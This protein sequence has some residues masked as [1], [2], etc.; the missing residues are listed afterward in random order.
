T[1]RA[2]LLRYEEGYKNGLFSLTDIETR[3]LKL[4]ED[5]A[6]VTSQR[7]KVA[8]IRGLPGHPI[9][10]LAFGCRGHVWRHGDGDRRGEQPRRQVPPAGAPHPAPSRRPTLAQAAA[11]R[12]GRAGVGN[13]RLGARV[14]RNL[15]PAQRL[16]AYPEQ[17]T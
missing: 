1:S 8:S 12:F 7:N 5:L 14:V 6:K 10:G 13:P 9:F 11:P 15:A 3:R 16:P 17:G 2:R 4:Q